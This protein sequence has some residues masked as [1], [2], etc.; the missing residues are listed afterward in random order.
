M[1][2][3]CFCRFF[4]SHQKTDEEKKHS[5]SAE[6]RIYYIILCMELIISY[7]LPD[8]PSLFETFFLPIIE[9]ASLPHC[10]PA[11]LLCI[12]LLQRF[13]IISL[14]FV[15]LSHSLNYISSILVCVAPT[16]PMNERHHKMGKNK[17]KKT[18]FSSAMLLNFSCIS[19]V[20]AR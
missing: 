15:H 6:P 14:L 11:A 7:F 2:V 9:S 5:R 13:H 17:L 19:K 10:A 3:L 8:H 12:L 18:S 20:E 4:F 16:W 1:A